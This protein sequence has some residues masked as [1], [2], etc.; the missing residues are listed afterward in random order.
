MYILLY[1]HTFSSPIIEMNKQ[2]HHIK[3]I[4][5]MCAIFEISMLF[6]HNTLH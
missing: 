4:Q 1:R 5:Q 2:F 6:I 3:F